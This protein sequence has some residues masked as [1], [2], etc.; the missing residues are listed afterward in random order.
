MTLYNIRLVLTLAAIVG[1][2]LGCLL[3]ILRRLHAGCR[4][5]EITPEWLE[6]FSV[7]TYFPMEN[8]LSEQDF[9]FLSRQPGYDRSLQKKLRSERLRIYKQ[10]L[11]RMIVDFNRLHMAA[12][13]LAAHRAEDHSD[14]FVKLLQLKLAFSAAVFRAEFCYYLCVLGVGSVETQQLLQSL[15]KMSR[16]LTAMSVPEAA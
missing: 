2:G 12:R 3:P 5:D 13:L 7:A 16:Q 10:Y 9:E 11:R 8:L 4:I 1:T 15:E 6:S 14:A